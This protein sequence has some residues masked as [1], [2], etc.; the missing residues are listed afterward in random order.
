MRI[1][2]LDD[3]CLLFFVRNPQKGPVKSRLAKAVGADVARELYR[4]FLLDMLSML[5]SSNFPLIICFYPEDA[6]SDLKNFLGR[7]YRYQPQRGADLGERMKEAFT[8]AFVMR[9]RRVVLIGSDI[10]DLPADI[11]TEAFTHLETVDTILGPS[12]DGGYYLIG[13]NREGFL[14]EAFRGLLWGTRGVSEKTLSIL[15]HHKRTA[16]L[17]PSWSDIDSVDDLKTFLGR[18]RHP[19]AAPRT[20]AYLHQMKLLVAD[21]QQ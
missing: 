3:R 15:R 21:D 1:I 19:S 2:P 20:L 13:F 4:N 9:F 14:P 11:I 7:D 8:D 5:E 12:S 16:H 18:N 10:P 17:L 6:L